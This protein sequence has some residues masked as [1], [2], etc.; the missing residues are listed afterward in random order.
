MAKLTSLFEMK[1]ESHNSKSMFQISFGKFATMKIKDKRCHH[2]NSKQQISHAAVAFLLIN[3]TTRFENCTIIRT[4]GRS[5]DVLSM[6]STYGGY[7]EIIKNSVIHLKNLDMK[8]IHYINDFSIILICIII[9]Q[10][11]RL[12]ISTNRSFSMTKSLSLY[13]SSL[14]LESSPT[15]I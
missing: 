13:P 14:F 6:W 11:E 8:I 3:Q 4:F 9:L 1:Q 7:T 10:K 15:R 5:V 12:A 2:F